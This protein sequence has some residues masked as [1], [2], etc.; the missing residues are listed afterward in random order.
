[1]DGSFAL[2]T[3]LY[4]N[5]FWPLAFKELVCHLSTQVNDID[6]AACINV[7]DPRRG[8]CSRFVPFLVYSLVY[9]SI[10]SNLVTLATLS[11]WSG[12]V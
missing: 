2:A 4:L 7:F 11:P 8:K 10:A 3:E 6:L 9:P 12:S 5:R 1:M